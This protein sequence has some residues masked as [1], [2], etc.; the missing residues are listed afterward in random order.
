MTQVIIQDP[1]LKKVRDTTKIKE[2]CKANAEA[3]A[4]RLKKA[5]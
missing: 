3:I 5:R 1:V 4:E 2:Y